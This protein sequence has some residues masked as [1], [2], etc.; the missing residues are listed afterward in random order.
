MKC[1]RKISVGLCAAI[2]PFAA[3]AGDTDLD[4]KELVLKKGVSVNYEKG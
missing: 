4:G 1:I 2:M 3:F